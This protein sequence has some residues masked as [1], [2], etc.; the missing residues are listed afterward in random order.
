MGERAVYPCELCRCWALSFK[1]CVSM[2]RA[3]CGFT[4]CTSCHF[5]R[6]TI[7]HSSFAC[8]IDDFL[9]LTNQPEHFLCTSY[10][11]ARKSTASCLYRK[12]TWKHHTYCPLGLFGPSAR[13]AL[14]LRVYRSLHTTCR[15]GVT[16]LPSWLLRAMRRLRRLQSLACVALFS[17]FHS[18]R[19]VYREYPS[20]ATSTFLFS[21]SLLWFFLSLVEPP[22]ALFLS[23]RCMYPYATL[24]D[25]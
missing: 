5:S 13:Y 24:T 14:K 18:V 8:L 1:V 4:S 22:S 10:R 17:T 19:C 25:W 20:I 21:G 12:A 9:F 15:L 3:T 2:G 16:R 6:S 23:A 11:V 7:Y